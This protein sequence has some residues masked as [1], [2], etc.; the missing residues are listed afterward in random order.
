MHS[1]LVQER[2]QVL[3]DRALDP[4][5]GRDRVNWVPV[6]HYRNRD[7]WLC[8]LSCGHSRLFTFVPMDAETLPCPV[9]HWTG[10][11]MPMANLHRNVWPWDSWPRRG[12]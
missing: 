5:V 4:T 9:C 7:M 3:G 6:P 8:R 11:G 10:T 12:L 1:V 2:P